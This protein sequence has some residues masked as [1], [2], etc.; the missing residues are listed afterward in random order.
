[1]I[2]RRSL[3]GATASLL[4]TAVLAVSSPP[5]SA[6]PASAITSFAAGDILEISETGKI[7]T[8][9]IPADYTIHHR[10]LA[11]GVDVADG[12]LM[13]RG[14]G[15][16]QL[17]MLTLKTGNLVDKI[18][19]LDSVTSVEA[20]FELPATDPYHLIAVEDMSNDGK[21]VMYQKYMEIGTGPTAAI[22]TQLWM[23][24][25]ATGAQVQ[26]D[27]GLPRTTTGA[28]AA[29]GG[30]DG[31]LSD[32]GS[33]IVFGYSNSVAGCLSPGTASCLFSVY[34]ANAD[35][36]GRTLVSVDG[37]GAQAELYIGPVAISG[38]GKVVTYQGDGFNSIDGADPEYRSRVYM[39]TLPTST[40]RVVSS[41][42][43]F[44]PDLDLDLDF[45]GERASSFEERATAGAVDPKSQ[46]TV[47]L[48]STGGKIFAN[49]ETGGVAVAP[50]T[51]IS[52]SDDGQWLAYATDGMSYIVKLSVA[53]AKLGR[54]NATDVATIQVG[55][56]GGVPADASSVVVNVTAVNG[57]SSG[58]LT[59]WPCNAPRPTASNV[60]FDAGEATP[61]LVI[62]KLD[63]AGRMCVFTSAAV[64]LL[65]DI[66]GYFPASSS[67]IG[68]TPD[69]KLDTRGSGKVKANGETF[70]KVTGGT[71]PAGAAAVVLNLTAT[72]TDGGGYV[73]SWP[74]GTP[75]PVASSLNFEAGLDR[76]NLV[77]AKVGDDGK[78]CLFSSAQTN[79]IADVAGYFPT[80]NDFNPITPD[81][82]LDTRGVSRVQKAGTREIE[83]PAGNKA[84]ALNVT[85]TLSGD[86]GY[87]T[88]YPCGEAQPTVSNLNYLG[89]Q[90]VANAVIVKVGAG[91]KICI[92]SD[93]AS[94]YIA[95]LSGTFPTASTFAPLTPVRLV[96][97]R[98]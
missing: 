35:G 78:V 58:Y 37:A 1:M 43:A 66:S 56:Q 21:V 86:A 68:I 33:K 14:D 9:R 74:C 8:Y 2:V 30:Y 62:S 55:G 57:S 17:S 69:R 88:V 94:D 73:T 22:D 41:R 34:A 25:P 79:L 40:T 65:I 26:I 15:R 71:V 54:L 6:V 63:P 60:N 91:N 90:D 85:S 12:A 46:P 36:T 23:W 42:L 70:V 7:V 27:A 76:A 98:K 97:T 28:N 51:H 53:D 75:R 83:V 81:R 11:T 18:S 24:T 48:R 64:D 38:D 59:V 72:G 32:D 52:M 61:N 95:D 89:G 93:Q 29:R 84:V 67:Y 3:I 13:L 16:Y 19:V 47:Q 96:D 77:I 44:K 50:A 31:K 80:L 87:T 82:L 4:L 45:T 20:S 92:Y 5:A 10:N 39:Y 49:A